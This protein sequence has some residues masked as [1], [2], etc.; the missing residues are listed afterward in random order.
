MSDILDRIKSWVYTPNLYQTQLD[1]AAEIES[2]RTEV[3]KLRALL[4]YE[5]ARVDLIEGEAYEW[6]KT[7]EGVREELY[8]A[9]IKSRFSSPSSSGE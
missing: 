5:K 6:R 1:A 7:A 8:A 9:S 3:L 2:L 4:R